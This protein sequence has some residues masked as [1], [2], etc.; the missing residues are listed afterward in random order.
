MEC[1]LR[2]KSHLFVERSLPGAHLRQAS[3]REQLRGGQ[4]SA[5]SGQ[6]EE[7][8]AARPGEETTPSSPTATARGVGWVGGPMSV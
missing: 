1:P 3:S 4:T 2:R 7:E 6:V 5:T 8:R